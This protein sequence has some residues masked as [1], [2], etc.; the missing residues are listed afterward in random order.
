MA[1]DK[2]SL[3]IIGLIHPL[4]G[5]PINSDLVVKATNRMD[6]LR[7]AQAMKT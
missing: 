2:C 3:F 6:E 7:L 5:L 4:A 1:I